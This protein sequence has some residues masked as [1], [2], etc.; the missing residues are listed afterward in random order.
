[1]RSTWTD[2]YLYL[3]YNSGSIRP[4]GHSNYSTFLNTVD[5]KWEAYSLGLIRRAIVGGRWDTPLYAGCRGFQ[6]LYFSNNKIDS[7]I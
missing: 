6:S 5:D 2:G 7:A 3:N 1:M 4:N